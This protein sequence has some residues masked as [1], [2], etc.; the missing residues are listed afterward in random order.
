MVVL[1]QYLCT[2]PRPS[3]NDVWSYQVIVDKVVYA[4]IR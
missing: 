4:S 1:Q 3:R 2:R